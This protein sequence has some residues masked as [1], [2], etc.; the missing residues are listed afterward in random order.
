MMKTLV[1]G[2]ATSFIPKFLDEDHPKKKKKNS[3]T[4]TRSDDEPLFALFDEMEEAG[5]GERSLEVAHRDLVVRNEEDDDKLL[6]GPLA[7]QVWKL[8]SLRRS[9]DSHKQS[10]N[11][12]ERSHSPPPPPQE[13]RELQ[14]VQEEHK[15]K[16]GVKKKLQEATGYALSVVQADRRSLT[17]L[18]RQRAALL[19]Q[20]RSY[21][22][23]LRAA[24]DTPAVSLSLA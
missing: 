7:N 23:T 12:L 8:A 19:A 1:A 5:A 11:E 15:E 22:A 21:A 17:Q 4:R 20:R 16:K 3:K 18:R 2:A 14:E 9:S 13:S 10:E 6:R 24:A